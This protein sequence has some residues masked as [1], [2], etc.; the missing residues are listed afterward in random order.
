VTNSPLNSGFPTRSPDGKQIAYRVWGDYDRPGDFRIDFCI[1]VMTLADG[2][3]GT[4]TTEL[5]NFPAWSPRGDL[6]SFTRRSH[7]E[8][9]DHDIHTMRPDGTNVKR[10]TTAGA[11]TAISRGRPTAGASSG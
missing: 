4:L 9:Y 5:D 3:I 6:I 1:G 2:S 10:L 7:G 8:D 11:T